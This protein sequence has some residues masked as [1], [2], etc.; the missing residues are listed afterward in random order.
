LILNELKEPEAKERRALA[1]KLKPII[2]APPDM[3]TVNRKGLHPYDSLNRMFVLAFSND[4]V[5]ITIDSQDRRWFC[6]W[7]SAPRMAPDA[8]ARLW[9]WYKAGGYEA[10]AA[11]LRARDVSAFNPSAAPAWTEFKA[12]LVEHGMSIAESY[13]VEMM[14]ARRGEFARGAVGSPFHAL[15]DRV[16]ASAP[17]GVKVPQA[18]L[19]HALKEA[20]WVDC[21]RLKSRANDTKKHIFC[22]PDMVQHSRSELR[23]LV[24]EPA[25]PLMVRVK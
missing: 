22:A 12:N 10:V 1:N 23:D 25:S 6:V 14:R 18:A 11:W 7:S 21:G 13:L 17:S 2:A 5:P 24:E 20:G 16:A 8:A 4:P 3:L 15:C 9:A 19:L